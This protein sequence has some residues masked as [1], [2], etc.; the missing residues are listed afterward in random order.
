MLFKELPKIK[1]LHQL[2][3]N[4]IISQLKNKL[5]ND[6]IY[7]EAKLLHNALNEALILLR[8]IAIQNQ[9]YYTNWII[10]ASH[11]NLSQYPY[12]YA[13]WKDFLDINKLIK[14]VYLMAVLNHYSINNPDNEPKIFYT[15]PSNNQFIKNPYFTDHFKEI[16]KTI[17]LD[18][19]K[20]NLLLVNFIINKAISDNLNKNLDNHIYVIKLKESLFYKKLI[21]KFSNNHN[22]MYGTFLSYTILDIMKF[23]TLHY[24]IIDLKDI[25]N[26]KNNLLLEQY[27]RYIITNDHIEKEIKMNGDEHKKLTLE[28]SHKDTEQTEEQNLECGCISNLLF[29]IN[30]FRSKFNNNNTYIENSSFYNNSMFVNF[31][32]TNLIHSRDYYMHKDTLTNEYLNIDDK[33]DS[34]SM[35]STSDT[36]S[37]SSKDIHDDSRT[38]SKNTITFKHNLMSILQ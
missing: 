9:P 33:E 10:M 4:N 27:N 31:K 2:M 37:S 34:S 8:S 25:L 19:F 29:F 12:N 21:T 35:D 5:N 32:N 18:N 15:N 30:K 11:N 24:N 13:L 6:I 3:Y 38:N 7:V 1:E 20:S 23:E 28:K 26:N 16:L 22:T 14:L 36:N 17:I